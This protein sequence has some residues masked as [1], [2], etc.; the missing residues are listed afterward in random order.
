MIISSCTYGTIKR[1]K[2]G[3]FFAPEIAQIRRRVGRRCLP[4]SKSSR[5]LA[6]RHILSRGLCGAI[7]ERDEGH[8]VICFVCW[9]RYASKLLQQAQ[10]SVQVGRKRKE[11]RESWASQVALTSSVGSTSTSS[12][13]C[14]LRV[15]AVSFSHGTCKMK[16]TLVAS[17]KQ[18]IF[19]H[20]ACSPSC[21][22]WS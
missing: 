21:H 10:Q 14:L 2:I 12:T 17:S 19:R 3:A 20:I 9:H 16:G 7:D 6:E 11:G 22:P 1:R 15:P 18:L 4:G 8:A 13:S 5:I